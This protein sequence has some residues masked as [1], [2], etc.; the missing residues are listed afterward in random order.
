[1]ETV[2]KLLAGHCIKEWFAARLKLHI[3]DCGGI[4][5][6]SLDKL[7]EADYRPT[8]QVSGLI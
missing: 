4:F 7:T 5:L 6:D 3:S 8:D 2:K 1:M